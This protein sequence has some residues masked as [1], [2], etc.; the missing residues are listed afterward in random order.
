MSSIAVQKPTE[1]AEAGSPVLQEIDEFFEK[2]RQR[3]FEI[4]QKNG[5]IDGHDV[6][7]WLQAER[8]FL[9]CPASELIEKD[10]QF[11]ISVAV[12]GFEPKDIQVTAVPDAIIVRGLARSRGEKEQ[13][14]VRFSE[15]SD[16]EMFRRVALPE[17]IDVNSASARLEKGLLYIVAKKANATKTA[18]AG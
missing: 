6:E 15:L 13:Q 10:R 7:H 1:P 2:I 18:A 4:F 17:P 8:E 11:E 14:S 12:P 9:C 16:K 3:A 5:S